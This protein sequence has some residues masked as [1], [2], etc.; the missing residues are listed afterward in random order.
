MKLILDRNTTVDVDSYHA[1]SDRVRSYCE[2]EDIGSM[3]FARRGTGR[4]FGTQGADAGVQIAFV[5][6]N[7]RVWLGV[8]RYPARNVEVTY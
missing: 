4:I 5:S 7:G 1:A 8:D 2:E 6:Y 3:E